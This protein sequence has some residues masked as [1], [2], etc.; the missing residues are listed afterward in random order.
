[1]QS[2]FWPSH[3]PRRLTVP[4]TPLPD[5]L[6]VS[7]R[8][9]P[10]KTAIAFY[11][12][13][14]AYAELWRRVERLAAHLQSACGVRPGDRV[15]L[16]TQNSPA[17]VAAYYAILRC[18]AVAVP[19]NP[20]NLAEELRWIVA[21]SGARVACVAQELWPQFQPLHA[22]G[23]LAHAVVAHYA[24]DLPERC[25]WPVPEVIAAARTTAPMQ[26]G[27]VVAMDDALRCEA[28]LAGH[29]IASEDIAVIAYTSGT[30]GRP[31]GCMLSHRALQA[32]IACLAAWNRWTA[33]AV[34]LATA[35]FFHVTGME[36]S[37]NLPLLAGATIVL[38]P[39]W[40]REAA[41]TLIERHG[42]THW[43][44]VPTMVTDLLALPG[45][46]RR[47]LSSLVYIG[48]GGTAMPEPVAARLHALTGLEYQEGW[49][50]TEVA[51]AIHL[52]PPGG[53]RR[54][55]LGIPTFGVDTRVMALD[56]SGEAASGENGELATRCPSLFSGYWNNPRATEEA[57]VEIDGRRFFRTGD[58]GHVDA[59]G[60]FHLADRLK[61]M[62]NASGYKVWPA[63]VEALLYG[64][65]AV[66]E[67]CVIG[68]R[69]AQR[70]ETVK[71]FV[72]LKDGAVPRPSAEA[73]IEWSRGHMAAYK[74]PRI[75]EFVDS[76]PKSGA[77]KI[78]WR[79]LQ[80]EARP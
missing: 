40:D 58:I 9:Y 3:L 60:Y 11:G 33:D 43:T 44:N 25:E 71:A 37:M 53:E 4:A 64:H 76:L 48:G 10:D 47:D 50:L 80:D 23:L 57:F 70:G 22:Q 8:R 24:A 51:G 35:P 72:V 46:E 69:D 36:G 20:M 45:I 77:G 62:I 39:R 7:A 18:A 41:A 28:A 14:I 27:G 56:G 79:R 15:V 78:L 63:E 19:V 21:D 74:I 55:C 73:L 68:V 31:K 59:D 30:T 2:R 49:G 6:E 38:L 61:R 32:A 17:F 1:M 67:A 26:A 13:S 16:D 65:P 42:A 12:R 52:N 5:N 54:Q 34:A 75:V 66:Q 29:A